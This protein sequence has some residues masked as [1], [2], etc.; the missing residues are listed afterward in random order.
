MSD[1]FEFRAIVREVPDP[2]AQKRREDR[3]NGRQ[4]AQKYAEEALLTM[5]TLMRQTQD[6][7]IKFKAAQAVMN[8]AWG[9]PKAM[10]DEDK[11]KANRSI[12]EVLAEISEDFSEKERQKRLEA[13]KP[14]LFTEKEALDAVLL[15]ENAHENRPG[16]SPAGTGRGDGGSGPQDA[17][18]ADH[19]AA[20]GAVGSASEADQSAIDLLQSLDRSGNV[21]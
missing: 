7:G 16:H 21:K 4:K 11:L 8:R 18:H 6:E 12:I 15:Q 1:G 20:P 13:Q 10:E 14:A 9:T 5:V 17:V 2:L 3:E 19:G